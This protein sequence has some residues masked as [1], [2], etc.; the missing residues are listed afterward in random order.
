MS[1]GLLQRAERG[2]DSARWAVASRFLI[3]GLVT[4]T[5]VS[6]IPAIQTALRLSNGMLGLCLLGAAIGSVAAIPITGWLV[7]R[8]GSRRVCAWTSAGF[9]AALV[10]IPLSSGALTLFLSLIVYG[11]MAGASDVAM[12]AH[13]VAVEKLGRTPLMSRFHAMFSLGGIAGAAGGGMIASQ[14]V[15]PL[16]HFV[17]AAAVLLL[18][19]AATAP[20]LAQTGESQ[21]PRPSRFFGRGLPAE[22]LIL[23]AI[24]FCIFLSEGAMADWTAVYLQ[25]TL[26]TGPGLAAAG[27]AVF[28]VGMTVFR[29]LGDSITM[30]LG[31]IRTIL[32]GALLAAAGLFIALLVHSPWLALP[33]FA[34]T[35]AGFSVIV[36]CVFAAGG[37]VEGISAAAGV[38]T[39]SGLGYLGFLVGPPLIGLISQLL[40]LRAGLGLVVGLSL[41]AAG[42][43]RLLP[44]FSE[45]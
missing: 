3:H 2:L 26:R 20:F 45:D 19:A 31:R 18:F 11:A 4:A 25:Q 14:R 29:L 36:P 9:C 8:F 7:A 21:N 43:S 33:G 30:R 5:W 37:R 28:S 42:M 39:V 41:L 27:Y 34:I 38:A 22:L 1:T 44:R 40:S 32:S 10:P 13:G 15:S 16:A 24:G 35:G 23:C 12:N 17:F 6:R